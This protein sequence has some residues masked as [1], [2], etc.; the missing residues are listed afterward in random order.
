MNRETTVKIHFCNISQ[1]TSGVNLLEI[2]RTKERILK[3]CHG[4]G[5]WCGEGLPS[6]SSLFQKNIF[7]WNSVLSCIFWV[8][9]FVRAFI[10]KM[11]NFSIKVMVWS[12][13]VDVE[14]VL[15]EV[16]NTHTLLELL[17]LEIVVHNFQS[18]NDFL[19]RDAFTE[20]IVSLMPWCS[21]IRPSV[22]PSVH[23]SGT[24]VHCDHTVHVRE[25]LR[26]WFYSPMFWAS[27]H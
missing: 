2:L 15:W 18:K 21:S 10:R 7:T 24:S 1:T 17:G 16:V 6:P 5:V 27:W 19:A 9:S 3:A 13:L 25:D 20:R 8:V 22:R 14:D 4:G 23:L 11:L 12:K 26:L